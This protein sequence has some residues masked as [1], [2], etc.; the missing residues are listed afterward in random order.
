MRQ[1]LQVVLR[2]VRGVPTEDLPALLGELE[3]VRYT[4]IARLTGPASPAPRESDRLVSVK[5]AADRL[6]ISTD[7][8]YRH[9]DDYS[10]TR[11]L[12]GRLLFSSA[13]IDQFIQLDTGRESRHR[14]NKR[15]SAP[16]LR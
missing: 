7:N 1:E 12:R 15:T 6:G 5:E 3:Q 9:A 14:R 13:G 16:R 2:V 8:L 11:R 4:A 10:F